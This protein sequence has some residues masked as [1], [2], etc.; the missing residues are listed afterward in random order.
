MLCCQ[1]FKAFCLASV[2]VAPIVVLPCVSLCSTHCCAPEALW[3]DFARAGIA[4][5]LKQP[6]PV[7]TCVHQSS[8]LQCVHVYIKAASRVAA[9]MPCCQPSQA[10]CATW[11][12]RQHNLNGAGCGRWR[13]LQTWAY[14]A[15]TVWPALPVGCVCVVHDEPTL[16]K[17]MRRVPKPLTCSL[18]VT[19]QKA[20]S[21]K[22]C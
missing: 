11:H 7:R 10:I 22:P 5:A 17:F 9:F 3:Q 4:I 12:Q 21:P 15:T 13:R 14:Q 16:V 8:P 20:I 6:A 18:A 19:A 1:P 2:C